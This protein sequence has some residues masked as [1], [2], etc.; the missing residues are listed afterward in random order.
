AE[1]THELTVIL[2]RSFYR[3]L[4]QGELPKELDRAMPKPPAARRHSLEVITDTDHR[5]ILG[6]CESHF[7][8]TYTVRFQ[9]LLWVL[10][11]AGFRRG[12][13]L[14]LRITDVLFDD[15]GGAR[16]RL[17]PQAETPLRLKTGP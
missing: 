7:P 4:H 8:R 2:A 15:Q 5:A 16:L 10:W 17:P 12:E 11:D 6:A 13:A 9:A 1:S 3:W 14:S